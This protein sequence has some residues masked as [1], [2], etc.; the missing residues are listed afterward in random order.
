MPSLDHQLL[1]PSVEMGQHN[2]ID[3]HIE[4]RARRVLIPGGPATGTTGYLGVTL[5]GGGLRL[6]R[7]RR[8]GLDREPRIALDVGKLSGAGHHADNQ[9]TVLEIHLD[10]A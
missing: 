10:T 6:R 7:I 9:L 1:R 4:A 8:L 3:V 2:L 5:P